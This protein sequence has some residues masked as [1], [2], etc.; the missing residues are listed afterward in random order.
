MSSKCIR[1]N[2]SLERAIPIRSQRKRF[3]WY[4][5]Q[6]NDWMLDID[7]KPIGWNLDKDLIETKK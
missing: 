7:Q 2:K 5:L 6:E 4:C 3:C 1:C